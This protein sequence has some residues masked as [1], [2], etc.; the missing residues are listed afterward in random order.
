MGKVQ[1]DQRQMDFITDRL[2]AYQP[3]KKKNKTFFV[4]DKEKEFP[5]SLKSKSQHRN[6]L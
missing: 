1:F 4:R 5:G 6:F 2:L 3:P